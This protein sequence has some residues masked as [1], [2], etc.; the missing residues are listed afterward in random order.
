MKL[1]KPDILTLLLLTAPALMMLHSCTYHDKVII[2][3]RPSAI[4][5]GVSSV[6][7]KGVVEGNSGT[8]RL[9]NLVGQCF[10]GS[11]NLKENAGFGVYGYKKVVDKSMILFDNTQVYPL[12]K[13]PSTAWTY[14]PIRFWDLTASYQFIAYWPFLPDEVQDNDPYVSIPEPYD[15]KDV[16]DAQKA[17]TLN[18]IPNWQPVSPGNDTSIDF[19]T[20]TRVGTYANDFNTGVVSF[21]FRHLLSQLV[22]KAYYVG[23]EQSDPGVKI[24]SITFSAYTPQT[25]EPAPVGGAGSYQVLGD[26][27]STI[28]QRYDSDPSYTPTMTDSYTLQGVSSSNPISIVFKD[29][30]SEDPDYIA[31]FTP[32]EVGR[33]LMVPHTWY[34]QNLTVDY[35]VGVNVKTSSDIP[36][37]LGTVSPAYAVQAGKIY[38]L[39]LIFDTTGGGFTVESVAIKN[40]NEYEI[41]KEVYNW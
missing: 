11:D 25:G 29:E 24:R 37:S 27:S 16:T 9:E 1:K 15:P 5:M 40:W 8:A 12:E 41:E 34:K 20:A 17:L 31:S 14:Y 23:K 18:K 32:T 21:T 10:D 4:V 3:E 33:W 38:V 28:S 7:T 26:G 22:I 35:S 13:D 30:M 39:T 36:V 2:D 6:A 19:M